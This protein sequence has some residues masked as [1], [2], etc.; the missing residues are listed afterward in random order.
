MSGITGPLPQARRRG[1]R[2][3]AMDNRDAVIALQSRRI[4]ELCGQLETVTGERDML[5]LE[6]QQLRCQLELRELTAHTSFSVLCP[7]VCA[8]PTDIPVAAVIISVGPSQT[9]GHHRRLVG[10]VVDLG[11]HAPGAD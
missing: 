3:P 8:L 2:S 4:A 10:Q 5:H 9:A 11:G 6:L 7:F 1:G